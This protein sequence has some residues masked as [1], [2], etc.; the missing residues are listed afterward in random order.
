M[1]AIAE[2]VA[3]GERAGIDRARILEILDAGAGQSGVLRAKKGK[4][5]ERDF[6]PHFSSALIHKDLGYLQDLARSLGQ[7]LVMGSA[8]RWLFALAVS[9]GMGPLD[10]SGVGEVIRG[11]GAPEG[12]PYMPRRT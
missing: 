2:A 1:A 9:K 12:A 4:L 10:F 11:G 6:S 5:L 8:A 7:P 3:T